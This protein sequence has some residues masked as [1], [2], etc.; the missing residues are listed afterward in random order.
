MD[1]EISSVADSETYAENTHYYGIPDDEIESRDMGEAIRNKEE[2]DADEETEIAPA[3]IDEDGE[4]SI[5]PDSEESEIGPYY[6]EP[7]EEPEYNPDFPD[8]EY[9]VRICTDETLPDVTG[10]IGTPEILGVVFE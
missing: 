3:V 10:I 1:T 5:P 7:A 4:I 8:E 6:G 2:D 9:E